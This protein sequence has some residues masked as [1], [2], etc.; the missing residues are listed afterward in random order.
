MKTDI[1]AMSMFAVLLLCSCGGHNHNHDHA[2]EEASH[3][4]AEHAEEEGHR[5]DHAGEIAFTKEQAKAAGLAIE[6]V[7]PSTFHTVIRTSGQI[8]APQGDEQ[9]V[10]ATAS[11]VLTYSRGSIAEGMAVKAGE[12]IASVSA[13]HLQ[14]GDPAVNAR[15]AFETAEREYQ[16]AERL[17]ADKIISAKEYE[18]AKLNYETARNAYHAQASSMTSRGIAIAPGMGGYIKQLLVAQ[19][20]YVTVGQPIAVVTRD[21]R[22]QLKAFVP[23]SE[24][25]NLRTI[26]SANFVSPSDKNVVHSLASLNGKLVS[27]GHSL[28]DNGAFVPAVF[29]FDNVGNIL[30]GSYVEVF[31]IGAERPNTITIPLPAI[32]EEQG[33]HFVYVQEHDEDYVKRQVTLGDSDGS[34]RVVISGLKAG[35]KVVVKGAYNVKLASMSTEIPHGHS[36]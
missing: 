24:Y 32:T 33:L 13:K 18:Q 1:L 19:G 30:P 21:R 6:T 7:T 25:G 31:L 5:H 34:R 17:V 28:S 9:T 14:D 2:G 4:E 27:Y 23:E 20:E 35:E 16:R 22:L 12:A 15:A 11:G 10:V 3:N 36:H 26:S 29:E 8:V